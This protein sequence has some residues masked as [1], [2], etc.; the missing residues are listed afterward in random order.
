MPRFV[1]SSLAEGVVIV[2]VAAVLYSVKPAEPVTPMAV[3]ETM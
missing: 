3:A 2:A 1:Y